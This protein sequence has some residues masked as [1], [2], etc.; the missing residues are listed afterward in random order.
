VP[1]IDWRGRKMVRVSAQA[2]NRP[3]QYLRLADALLELEA[4]A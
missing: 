3:E 2:Y 1:I 4:E